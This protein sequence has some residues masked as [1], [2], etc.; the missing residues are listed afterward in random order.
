MAI[1]GSFILILIVLSITAHKQIG[2]LKVKS[3]SE[4]DSKYDKVPGGR[5]GA[6]LDAE[7]ERE[8]DK[9]EAERMAEAKN[10]ENKGLSEKESDEQ[11][12][13]K[14]PSAEKDIQ[15]AEEKEAAQEKAEA[16]LN[17]IHKL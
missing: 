13:E 12:K 3:S 7:R 8:A 4:G 14:K 15:T 10:Q 9:E 11:E 5:F 6:V 2:L 1:A 16:E 17:V